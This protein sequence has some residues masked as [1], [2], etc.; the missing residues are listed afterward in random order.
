MTPTP[1]LALVLGGCRE[2]GGH[3]EQGWRGW[4]REGGH[5]P[6][7]AGS[8]VALGDPRPRSVPNPQPIPH[9][10][11]Q[12]HSPQP[13]PTGV[14]RGKE[15]SYH[16]AT[17]CGTNSRKQPTCTTNSLPV[18]PDVCML[19]PTAQA[20]LAELLLLC[21]GRQRC[22]WH[23]VAMHSMPFTCFSSLRLPS[24]NSTSNLS[25]LKN[26]LGKKRT[27]NLAF[28]ITT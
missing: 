9:P 20:K 7:A 16:S 21:A 25:R 19:L 22:P 26:H 12:S 28:Q 10:S 6:H 14:P 15:Q 17:G 8:T 2:S 18:G 27:G 23:V 24:P 1:S 11:S 13:N 4:G 5:G 3:R